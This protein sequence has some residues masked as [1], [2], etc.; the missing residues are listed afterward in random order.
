VATLVGQFRTWLWVKMLS[1]TGAKDEEIAKEADIGNPK[2]LY[3]LRQELQQVSTQQLSQVLP[4]LLKLE[5]A[6]KQGQEAE[7]A[8]QTHALMICQIMAKK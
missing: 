2:R 8:L 1:E 5:F 3:F 4:E 7:M 6:L